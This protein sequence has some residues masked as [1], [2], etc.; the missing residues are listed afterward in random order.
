[1]LNVIIPAAGVG[2]RLRPH[3]HTAPKALLQVAGKP[4]LGH[5]LDRLADLK[6]LGTI[7]LVVGFLAE[8]IEEYVKSRYDLDIRFVQQAELKGLGFAIHL[9]LKEIPN[10]DPLMVI[11]GDTILEIDLNAFMDGPDDALGVC[12]VEDPRRFGV[13]ETN[14][15]L[16][17]HLVEKPE[18]PPSNLAVVGLYGIKNTKMLRQCL[19]DVVAKNQTAAGELQMTDALQLMV[20]RGSKMHARHVSGWYD[21][22]KSETLLETNRH[23][24]ENH[25]ETYHPPDSIVVPPSYISPSAR[26]ER[27]IIGPHVSIGDGAIIKESVIVNSI[28][29]DCAEVR[30]CLLSESLIGSNAVVSGNVQRLNVGDSS[31]VGLT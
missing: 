11:L 22:G 27:S 18:I 1:M 9:A 15:G 25:H 21:C 6:N 17:T 5:I 14:D 20:D 29:S 12:E 8:K 2:T 31:E 16:I 3:T 23:L 7:W 24:L 28:I 10:D 19:S 26:I 4:I 13:V 30:R